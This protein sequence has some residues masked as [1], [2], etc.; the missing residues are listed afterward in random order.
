MH[1][2]RNSCKI[3]ELNINLFDFCAR[4]YCRKMKVVLGP[5][6]N[7]YVPYKTSSF[8]NNNLLYIYIGN[9]TTLSSLPFLPVVCE[10]SHRISTQTGLDQLSPRVLP[11]LPTRNFVSRF[12][13]F[14]LYPYAKILTDE[15]LF[16][17]FLFRFP[18]FYYLPAVL[19]TSPIAGKQ[20]Y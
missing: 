2:L 12:Y 11:Y 19:C 17:S 18:D 16:S 3:N 6:G 14:Y 7:S 15:T 20:V 4:I 13:N 1:K 9:K 5:A 10:F 8:E